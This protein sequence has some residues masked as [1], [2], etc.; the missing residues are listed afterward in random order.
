MPRSTGLEVFGSG[1]RTDILVL[2][3]LLKNTYGSELARLLGLAQPSIAQ[4][5]RS[6]EFQGLL[7]LT[8]LGNQRMISLNPRFVGAVELAALLD[9]LAQADPR[10]MEIVSRLRRRPRQSGKAL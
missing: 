3:R 5:V 1:L 8:S 6:L 7:A 2:V 4:T 9:K 10:Y